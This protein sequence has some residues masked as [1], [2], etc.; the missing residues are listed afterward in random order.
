MG[1]NCWGRDKADVPD[2]RCPD[3]E[4]EAPLHEDFCPVFDAFRDEMAW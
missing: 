4:E 2:G 1:L 3:C